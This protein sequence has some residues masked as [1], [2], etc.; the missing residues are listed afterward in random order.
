MIRD[1]AGKALTARLADASDV[2][3]FLTEQAPPS[4]AMR[5]RWEAMRHELTSGGRFALRGG[6]YGQGVNCMDDV[7]ALMRDGWAEGANR[8]L[9][10]AAQLRD[11]LPPPHSVKRR[12]VWSDNG[13]DLDR[14][15]VL[16][17]QL[18]TAWRRTR[19]E[20]MPAQQT[21]GLALPW[22]HSSHRTPEQLFWGAA[23]AIAL[24]D[25]LENAGYRV[26]LTAINAV[27]EARSRRP[28]VVAVCVK[29]ASEA[30]RPDT[31]AAMFAHAGTYRTYGI[32]STAVAQR[33]LNYGWGPIIGIQRACDELSA[34]GL[35][36]KPDFIVESCYSQFAAAHR[37]Q[38]IITAVQARETV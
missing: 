23:A 3:A 4:T 36:D 5:A 25:L 20:A 26:E 10:L 24:C 14:D 13:D 30:L 6:W 31:V 34:A 28:V 27:V 33:E 32:A 17:G 12:P 29:G 1:Y 35:L 8:A 21:V 9:A 19:R 22:V 7:E 11:S 38:E 2:P 18:D 15:R 37:V 16:S